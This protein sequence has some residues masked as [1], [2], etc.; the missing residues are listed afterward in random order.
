MELTA[1]GARVERGDQAALARAAAPARPV[2]LS[3]EHLLDVVPALAPLLPDPGVRRGSVLATAGPA[4]TSLALALA[5]GPSSS[6]SWVGAVGLASLGLLAAAEA[7]VALGR[8]VLV[9][10]PE[11]AG[12][13]TVVATLLDGVDVV[14]AAPPRRLPP[15]DARRLQA[16][17]RE[18]QGVLVLVGAEAVPLDV[19][20][21]LTAR[22]TAWDGLADGAGHLRARRVTVEAVGRRAAARPRQATLWLPDPEG[23]AAS[24]GATVVSLRGAS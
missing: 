9:A 22:A 11:P 3:R 1:S 12:W 20:V 5:A 24:E 2:A 19:D 10:A 15:G 16:R 7:G 14:L 13:A 21:T 8:L 4:A 6:G 23:A 18:R 17:V